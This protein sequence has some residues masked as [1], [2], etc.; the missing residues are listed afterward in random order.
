[1]TQPWFRL[2]HE[3]LDDPKVQR[4]DPALFKTWINL[5]CLAARHDGNLPALPD[6]AFS[7]RTDKAAIER[8]LAE[9]AKLDLIEIVD[10]I[11]KPHAWEE[12]Q[13]K[14]DS[15]AER[16]RRYRER[17]R[18]R[19][20]DGESDVTRDVTVAMQDSDSDSEQNRI[21]SRS[22]ERE[23]I[24]PS[25]GHEETGKAFAAWN[26]LAGEIDLARAT[27]LTAPRRAKLRQRL[28]DAGGLDGWRQGLAK[29]R[30][31]P[32]LR[33][34]NE[35]GWRADLDFCLQAKSWTR[36]V[37]GVYDRKPNG[38]DR[39]DAIRRGTERALQEIDRAVGRGHENRHPRDAP[40]LF[41]PETVKNGG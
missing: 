2:Y 34:D 10:S 32:F 6:I 3:V 31:S 15:S 26:E 20:G 39:T 12:R 22:N 5:L 33:G 24:L 18:N 8:S 38:E 36:L 14:S 7:L 17:R 37:E 16:Q 19:N 41:G 9:L 23:P 1:M 11:A 21:E 40:A 13:F 25:N 30:D 29:V 35:R 28:S 27:R 4:L